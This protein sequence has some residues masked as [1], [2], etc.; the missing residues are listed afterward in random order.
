[1]LLNRINAMRKIPN[2]AT[3][4]TAD[5][6]HIHSPSS[7][8]TSSSHTQICAL[9]TVNQLSELK[10]MNPLPYRGKP[11]RPEPKFF[12]NKFK[13][14]PKLVDNFLLPQKM[15]WNRHAEICLSGWSVRW[16][17]DHQDRSVA[18][19]L[20]GQINLSSCGHRFTGVTSNEQ[21]QSVTKKCTSTRYSSSR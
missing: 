15:L 1:M 13:P 14:I 17:R 6:W 5:P 19:V 3:F 18:V 16:F 4:A 20:Y 12:F 10:G 9:F 21:Q 11:I 7:R 2:F 8:I